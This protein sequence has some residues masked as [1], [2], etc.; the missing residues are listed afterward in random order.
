VAR[1]FR[2]PPTQKQWRLLE[3]VNDR[4]PAALATLIRDAPDGQSNEVMGYVFDRINADPRLRG[5]LAAGPTEE[6]GAREHRCPTCNREMAQ[7]SSGAYFS[8]WHGRPQAD[9]A[10]V[11]QPSAAEPACAGP[12]ADPEVPVPEAQEEP[13]RCECGKPKVARPDGRVGLHQPVRP[14]PR[15]VA[16]HTTV[17]TGD[18]LPRAAEDRE[19]PA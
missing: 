8:F 10:T 1:G 14:W 3:G 12:S 11:E 19:A 5:F 9:G 15:W 18:D 2:K 16:T 4:D 7:G 17:A 13:P 6:G